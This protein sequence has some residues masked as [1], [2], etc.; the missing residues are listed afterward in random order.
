LDAVSLPDALWSSEL[1][2]LSR[3]A[4]EKLRRWRPGTLG[5]AS[6][7]AGVSPADVA[8]LM[9]HARRFAARKEPAPAS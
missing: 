7:I 9:V 4:L 6:R 5:M 2:G 1:N 8:V 3:E